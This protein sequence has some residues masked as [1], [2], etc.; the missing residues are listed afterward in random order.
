MIYC[1]KVIVLTKTGKNKEK[2]Y[3]DK[4]IIRLPRHYLN[5]PGFAL[6]IQDK[7]HS[8]MDLLPI[9]YFLSSDMI[10]NQNSSSA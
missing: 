4:D 3:N 1:G 9:Y 7:L 8:K 5:Q 10:T 6:I 2:D